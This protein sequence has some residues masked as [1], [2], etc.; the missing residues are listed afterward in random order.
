MSERDTQ[1]VPD[2]RS[3]D[4]QSHESSGIENAAYNE[5]NEA[6]NERSSNIAKQNDQLGASRDQTL[7]QALSGSYYPTSNPGGSTK[8]EFVAAINKAWKEGTDTTHG[9]TGN[10]AAGFGKGGRETAKIGGESFGM[11]ENDLKRY[12]WQKKYEKLKGKGC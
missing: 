2:D 1:Q 12:G 5:V 4:T 10:G 8:P 11:E 7:M 3:Q 9:A 6:R